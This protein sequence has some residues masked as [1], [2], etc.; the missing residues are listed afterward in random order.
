M[1]EKSGL[2]QSVVFEEFFIFKT[3]PQITKSVDP[4][5]RKT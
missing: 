3:I 5:K 4:G 2:I 1:T